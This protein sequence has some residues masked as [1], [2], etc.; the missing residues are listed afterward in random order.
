MS[1]YIIEVDDN[2]VDGLFKAKGFNTLVFDQN[3]L[4]KLQK[5]EELEPT[6]EEKSLP[7][8]GDDYYYIESSGSISCSTWSGD[9]WDKSRARTGNCFLTEEKAEFAVNQREVLAEMEKF[10]EPFDIEWDGDTYHYY[11]SY[12]YDHECVAVHQ[13]AIMRCGRF[14]F[15]SE[16]KA[17]SCIRTVGRDRIKKYYLGVE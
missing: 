9:C 4:D 13:N 11:I 12:D 5:Y 6:R 15:E 16:Q 3:G 8:N 14:Y 2:V 10:A 1:K 7:K 17:R